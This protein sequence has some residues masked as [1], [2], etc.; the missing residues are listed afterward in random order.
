M[1]SDT[2]RREFYIEWLETVIRDNKYWDAVRAKAT[3]EYLRISPEG[4]PYGWKLVP[5]DP[6]SCELDDSAW[7]LIFLNALHSHLPEDERPSSWHQFSDDQ[8]QRIADA[9]RV[10]VEAVHAPPVLRAD[11]SPADREVIGRVKSSVAHWPDDTAEDQQFL[12]DLHALIALASRAGEKSPIEAE[13]EQAVGAWVYRRIT[14]LEAAEPGTLEGDELDYLASVVSDVEEYGARK[15]D[16]RKDLE[17]SRL[18]E[19]LWRQCENGAREILKAAA[20]P[21]FPADS[22][23]ADARLDA[24]LTELDRIHK[25]TPPS[26]ALTELVAD[27]TEIGRVTWFSSGEDEGPDCGF[28]LGLNDGASLYLGEMPKSTLIDHGI[29]T[30]TGDG[31]WF[32]LYDGKRTEIAARVVDGDAARAIFDRLATAL[33][34]LTND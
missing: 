11:P 23:G 31:W 14:T 4:M 9:W 21:P 18:P 25:P 34:R 30:E 13:C 5:N 6:G 29:E 16:L 24:T 27:E 20:P 28:G 8:R 2:P 15:M 19:Q 26:D 10:A 12:A 22:S 33:A 3:L 32:V 17:G 1:T 7:L